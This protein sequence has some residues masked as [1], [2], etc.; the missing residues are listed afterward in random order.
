MATS[1]VSFGP[2]LEPRQEAARRGA[3]LLGYRRDGVTVIGSSGE[4]VSKLVQAQASSG[5]WCELEQVLPG[6]ERGK[7]YVNGAAARLVVDLDDE[8][9]AERLGRT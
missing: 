2:D 7:V 9:A 5:G 4:V 8:A 1:Y 6:G 3:R